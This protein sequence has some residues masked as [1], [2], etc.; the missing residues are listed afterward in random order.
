MEK[1]T[2][3]T[4][5]AILAKHGPWAFFACAFLGIVVC[6]Q[7]RPAA[8][9]QEALAEDRVK[10]IAAVTKSIELNTSSIQQMTDA[11][12]RLNE[13]MERIETSSREVGQM[14]R[15]FVTEVTECHEE[16][17]K[18]LDAIGAKLGGT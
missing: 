15:G 6:Y 9:A 10:L 16:Q 11:I 8:I 4:L 7:L 17:Q 13:T 1:S 12:K 14:M 2:N 3:G 5:L 18:K